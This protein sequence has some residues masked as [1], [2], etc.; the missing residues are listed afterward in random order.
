MFSR[1]ADTRAACSAWPLAA[2]AARSSRGASTTRPRPGALRAPIRPP[3]P[4]FRSAA[5]RS[6]EF[7][8]CLTRYLLKAEVLEALHADKSLSPRLRAA[9]LEIAEHRTENASGLYRG[10]L[11]RC[12]AAGGSA[13]DY[14]LAVRRLEAACQVVIDDPE[15]LAEYKGALALALYRAGQPARAIETIDNLGTHDP[16]PAKAASGP[17][18]TPLELAVTAMASQQLGDTPRA[19]AALEQFRKLVQTDPWANDQ[20]AR[21]LFHEAE[22]TVGSPDSGGSPR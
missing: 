22:D 19:R 6:S 20:E 4:S 14:R 10:R 11:A 16:A 3:P 12:P 21:V 8:R 18:V 5:P 9:A 2:T 1:Y 15:R 17:N 13:D 7:S